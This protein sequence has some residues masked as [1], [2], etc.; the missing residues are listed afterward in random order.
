VV[1]VQTDAVLDSVLD[2]LVAISESQSTFGQAENVSSLDSVWALVAKGKIT[3]SQFVKLVEVADRLTARNT[4]LI[5]AVGLAL[6]HDAVDAARQL[7]ER[8]QTLYPDNSELQ[9]IAHILAGA[10]AVTVEAERQSN[11]AAAM[12]WLR[13]QSQEYGGS[14][15]ALRGGELLG[16]ASSRKT[17]VNQLGHQLDEDVLITR[18]PDTE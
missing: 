1:A 4:L 8:G 14:W 16:T 5:Q 7:A 15:V 11:Q 17:L 18:I 3:V 2:V 9:R 12:Y 10:G 6:S 13:D